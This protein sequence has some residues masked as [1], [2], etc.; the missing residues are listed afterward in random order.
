M[1]LLVVQVTQQWAHTI[2]TRCILHS[3]Y[4]LSV[5]TVNRTWKKA[6]SFYYEKIGQTGNTFCRTRSLVQCNFFIFD[7]VT[8]IQFKICDCVQNFIKIWWFFTEIWQYIDF[9]NGSRLPSLSF[10][11]HHMRPLMKSLLLAA[12]A[13]Q[14]S[15]QSDKQIWR[16]SYLIFLHI[17]LQMPIQ[18]QNEGFG[19]LWTPKC[20]YSSRPAKSTS[21]RKSASF[22][23]PTVK[24]RRGV[25][26]EGSWQKV[27]R[28]HR[29]T[30]KFIFCPCIALDRQ[31]FTNSKHGVQQKSTLYHSVTHLLSCCC[32]CY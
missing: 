2:R 24:I 28:T 19:R 25:R 18:P 7:H 3:Q 20:D 4:W 23:L 1:L 30:G 14:I 17:W 9:Q 21:L 13:C 6:I 16:Y 12:A 27:W 5:L 26:P 29:H 10:F 8:F 32:C 22:N 15:C 31:W 11:Y